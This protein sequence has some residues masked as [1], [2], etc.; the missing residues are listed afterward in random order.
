MIYTLTLN[1]S[2]DYVIDVENLELGKVNRTSKDFKFPGGKGINVSRILGNQKIDN[3]ALGFLGGFTGK[4]IEDNLNSLGVK[5]E[6]IK[7]KGDSR[8][9][10]KIKSNKETEINSDGPIISAENLKSLFRRL[11]Q[12]VE[13]DILVLAGS[14]PSTLPRDL[15]LQIQKRVS[16]NNVKVVVDTSGKALLEAIK[17]KPFLIKPNNHEIEEIFNVKIN[18]EEELIKY[19]KELVSLGAENVII[20]MAGDGALLIT[21][22]GVFKGNA[23]KGEVKNSVGAGDSLV[24]G[25]LAKYVETKDLIS[26]FKNGIASGSASAFSLDLALA[27]DVNKLLPIIKIKRY[28][29]V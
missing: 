3:I 10:V 16:Q 13:G 14:I 4:F 9:N 15:Y 18:S 8:I 26:S 22:Y 21:K 11:D 7:V 23:P 2:I 5:T 27:E 24:G 1:P 28:E 25:F 12:L 19:G 17:N 29:E 20:S 6:F